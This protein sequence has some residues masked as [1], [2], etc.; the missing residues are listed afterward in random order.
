[1]K[2]D[3]EGSELRMLDGARNTIAR[4]RPTLLV[5]IE[6]AHT[7]I[8]LDESIAYVRAMGYAA[9][10]YD[11]HGRCLRPYADLRTKQRHPAGRGAYVFNFIFLPER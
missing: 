5:E 6:E 4:D 9:Y 7:G 8:P 10:F 11:R 3:V 2:I 1:M